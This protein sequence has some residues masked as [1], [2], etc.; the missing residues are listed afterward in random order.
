MLQHNKIAK[1]SKLII[2][3]YKGNLEEYSKIANEKTIDSAIKVFKK[4]KNYETFNNDRIDRLYELNNA[5]KDLKEIFDIDTKCMTKNQI[6]LKHQS[7]LINAIYSD[8]LK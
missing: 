3:S 8:I 2:N 5:K 7:C 4:I 6:F 1:L